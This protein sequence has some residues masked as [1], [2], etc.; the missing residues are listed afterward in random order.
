[1][2]LFDLESVLFCAPLAATPAAIFGLEPCFRSLVSCSVWLV[3]LPTPL[4]L[5]LAKLSWASAAILVN[6]SFFFWDLERML[7]TPCT[8]I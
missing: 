7:A 2:S 6:M 5:F 1:M 8:I 4:R 3:L